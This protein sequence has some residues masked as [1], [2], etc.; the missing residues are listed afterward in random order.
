MFFAPTNLAKLKVARDT[1][2]D[3]YLKAIDDS[4]KLLKTSADEGVD[5]NAQTLGSITK[6]YDGFN[7]LAKD[8]FG[9]IDESVRTAFKRLLLVGNRQVM[10]DGGALKLFDTNCLKKHNRR[11]CRKKWLNAI[12]R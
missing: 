9:A 7:N 4:F 5:L 10:R 11:L 12:T 2:H 8:N 6:A 3:S 1:A